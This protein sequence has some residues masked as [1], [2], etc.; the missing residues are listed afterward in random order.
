M[1][2]YFPALLKVKCYP[3]LFS[4]ATLKK[5]HYSQFENN[6]CVTYLL[7]CIIQMTVAY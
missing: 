7:I 5:A 1:K 6:H 4:F 3:K 2:S